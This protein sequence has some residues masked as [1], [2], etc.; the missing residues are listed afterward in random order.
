[1]L[2][3]GFVEA[4]G[5]TVVDILDCGVGMAQASVAEP[6]GQTAV[7]TLGFLSVEQQSQPLGM[8]EFAGLG[9]VTQ[10]GEGAGHAVQL[11]MLE[12]IE[13]GMLQHDVSLV[14][15]LRAADIGMIDRRSVRGLTRCAAIEVVLEDGGDRG[16]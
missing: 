6:V 4:P 15:V 14:K 13:G 7:V 11:E 10:F 16:V 9:V 1:M 2:E 5:G 3:Q 12:L 8:I